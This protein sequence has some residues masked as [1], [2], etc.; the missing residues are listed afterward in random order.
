MGLL[1]AVADLLVVKVLVDIVG[2]FLADGALVEVADIQDGCDQA[3][4]VGVQIAAEVVGLLVLA[5][6]SE[7]ARFVA[8][9][10]L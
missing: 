4:F 3:L 5:V 2:S 10:N 6:H 7:R 8:G 9:D 1:V